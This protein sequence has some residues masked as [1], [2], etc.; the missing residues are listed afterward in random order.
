MVITDLAVRDDTEI[1]ILRPENVQVR[2][3]NTLLKIDTVIPARGDNA[4]LQFFVLIDDT[5]D[6][7]IGNSLNHVRDFINEQPATMA[8]GVGY[9]SNATVQIAQNFT[10]D[11]AL[12]ASVCRAVNCPPWTVL[13]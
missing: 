13:T 2:Q 5:C 4:A 11:H 9:M 7:S 12:A 1:P 8:I 3:G 6:S 10:A